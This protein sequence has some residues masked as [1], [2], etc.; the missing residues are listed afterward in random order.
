MSKPETEFNWK[1]PGLRKARCKECQKAYYDGW[2]A[3][4][5]DRRSA[6]A[7]QYHREH[8]VPKPPRVRKPRDRARDAERNR[9][10]RHTWK[11]FA[12]ERWGALNSRT[13]N[14]SHPNWVNP[15][16]LVY[17]RAGTELRMTREEFMG[18]CETR[19]AQIEQMY[20]DGLRPSLDRIDSL[21][22]YSLDN[23]QLLPLSE[24]CRKWQRR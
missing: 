4:T 9:V 14:G 21:G 10:R 7:K 24:N 15:Q 19:A 1:R 16:H 6:Y 20:R 8:Y 18:W 12:S 22:H 2:L 3:R 11:G 17:L 23:I 5:A 13:V